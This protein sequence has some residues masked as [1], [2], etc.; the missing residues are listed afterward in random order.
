MSL[1]RDVRDNEWALLPLFDPDNRGYP[2]P[3][4]C[5]HAANE[6]EWSQSKALVQQAQDVTG[7]AVAIVC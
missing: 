4:Q 6:Q 1:L 3:I 5:L 7:D 2:Q